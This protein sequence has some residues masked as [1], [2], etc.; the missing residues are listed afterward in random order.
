MLDELFIGALA[1]AAGRRG[2][3]SVRALEQSIED[4]PQPL[5]AL[6]FLQPED[7]VSVIAEI[8]RASPSRG[9]L[10]AIDEPDQLGYTYQQS[11]ASA[12]S[13]LTEP[14]S[15]LGS[16]EDLRLVR[17]K[18]TIPLL[19]KDFI[20]SEYQI[21]E[22]RANGADMVLLIA[23]WLPGTR[24]ARLMNFANALGMTALVETHSEREIAAA[25][26]AGAQIV[27]INTRDLTT[28]HTDIALF[29]RLATLLPSDVLRV[30]ESSVRSRAD[31]ERY[32]DAGAQAVLIGEA[33]VTG[34]AAS[35]LQEFS[36]VSI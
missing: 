24:L 9:M 2:Q 12:I 7:H 30:A 17:A 1:D 3:T 15:F 22:A 18:V 11:G 34:D 20:A 36:R 8:K 16:L 35:L 4:L 29:E 5:D 23:T 26:A 32:R 13:V 6:S 33:L 28:F 21:L 19:R 14:R 10:S 31:I 25:V 27:G